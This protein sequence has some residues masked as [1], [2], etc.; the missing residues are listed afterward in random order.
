MIRVRYEKPTGSKWARW[1]CPESETKYNQHDITEESPAW[2]LQCG[3]GGGEQLK[4]IK[5][6][7]ELMVMHK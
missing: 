2:A 6:M 3:W 5:Q 7:W 1:W 4:A